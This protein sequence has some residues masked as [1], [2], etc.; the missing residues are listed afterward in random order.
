MAGT[1]HSRDH[2]INSA[3]VFS[4]CK[5]MLVGTGALT[6]FPGT[7]L[8]ECVTG[9]EAMTHCLVCHCLRPRDTPVTHRALQVMLS[10]LFM[11]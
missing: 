6:L 4:Q 3:R 7:P 8:L 10:D 1:E 2:A 11:A 5:P 9:T